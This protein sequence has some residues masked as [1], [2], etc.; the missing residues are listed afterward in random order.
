MAG[1]ANSRWKLLAK[2]ASIAAL[3]TFLAAGLWAEEAAPATASPIKI[4]SKRTVGDQLRYSALAAVSGSMTIPGSTQ[5]TPLDLK[6]EMVVKYAVVRPAMP[7]T[8]EILISTESAYMLLGESKVQA[9][10]SPQSVVRLDR[11]GKITSITGGD[12]IMGLLGANIGSLMTLMLPVFPEDAIEAGH[13]WTTESPIDSL[14]RKLTVKNT[15]LGIERVDERETAKLKQ[16]FE[17]A[18]AEDAKDAPKSAGV[19]ARGEAVSHFAVDDGSLIKSH[20]E[21]TITS[22]G[23]GGVGE[24]SIDTKGM[25]DVKLLPK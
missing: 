6:L 16:V 22:D 23:A 9:P 10:M 20:A 12:K 2:A 13:E 17:L 3:A 8:T 4:T 18:F 11:T 24:A 14:K 25:L 7:E 19:S 1:S 5:P 21:V 15:L